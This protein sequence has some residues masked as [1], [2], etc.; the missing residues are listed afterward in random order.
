MFETEPVYLVNLQPWRESSMENIIIFLKIVAVIFGLY[1]LL[2]LSVTV[3]AKW[4]Y[5]NTPKGRL[6][7]ATDLLHGIQRKFPITYQLVCIVVCI[8]ILLYQS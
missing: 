3:R 8:C 4:Q 6:L 5:V 1:N 7:A 2:S